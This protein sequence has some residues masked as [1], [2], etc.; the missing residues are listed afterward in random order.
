MIK[1]YHHNWY[2]IILL[3]EMHNLITNYKLELFQKKL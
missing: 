2:V 3:A 1:M